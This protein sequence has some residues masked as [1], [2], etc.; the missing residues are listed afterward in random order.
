MRHA[1]TKKKL[2]RTAAHRKATMQSLSSALIR[3]KRIKTT[4]PK[5]KALRSF[6]EPIINRAKEDTTHNRRQAF[7]YLQDKEAVKALFGEVAGTL[8]ERPG[9]Y[10]RVVKLGMRPGDA[11]EMAVIELVDFNDVKPEGTAGGRKKTRRGG[12]RGRRRSG[13]A[14]QAKAT[15]PQAEE[16][17]AEAP[18]ET[19]AEAPA[20]APEEQEAEA[21]ASDAANPEAT[22][23]PQ[24]PLTPQEGEH[25]DAEQGA[26]PG[27]GEPPPEAQS[28]NQGRSGEHR[29]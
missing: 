5:A 10:T 24:V 21:V 14:K 20:E 6:V 4:L 13:G 22:G 17:Q 15:Q 11:A 29:G 2:G 27:T 3:H 8:G 12:G 23:N 28:E 9:G 1:N 16:P 18:A 7:R 26:A 25:G 19:S